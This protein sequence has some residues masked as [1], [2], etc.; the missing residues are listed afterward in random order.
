MSDAKFLK[1]FERKKLV[2][3]F[4]LPGGEKKISP[5][6]IVSPVLNVICRETSS[7]TKYIDEPTDFDFNLNY[8]INYNYKLNYNIYSNVNYNIYITKIVS[9]IA[10]PSLLKSIKIIAT[11]WSGTEEERSKRT[12]SE[13]TSLLTIHACLLHNFFANLGGCAIFLLDGTTHW[14]TQCHEIIEKSLV[15]YTWFECTSLR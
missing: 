10:F 6:K 1:S 12:E 7:D 3:N 2:G 5:V 4:D 11:C 13:A 9:D 14:G 15:H 8:Y